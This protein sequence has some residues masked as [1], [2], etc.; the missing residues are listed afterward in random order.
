MVYVINFSI[1]LYKLRVAAI[2]NAC[3]RGARASEKRAKIEDFIPF[4]FAVCLN[5][6]TPIP[7]GVR[8]M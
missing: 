2:R 8:S 5:A 1:K 4:S 3:A 7:L 6:P